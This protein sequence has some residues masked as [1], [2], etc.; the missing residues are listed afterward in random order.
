MQLRMSNQD[1]TFGW[2]EKGAQVN[3]ASALSK[4]SG[5]STAILSTPR[6]AVPDRQADIGIRCPSAW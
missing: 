5:I 3:N 2:L 1:S 4:R 6:P